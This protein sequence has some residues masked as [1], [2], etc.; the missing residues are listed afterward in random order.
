MMSLDAAMR[1]GV[2]Q[3]VLTEASR[4]GAKFGAQAGLTDTEWLAVLVE[5]V[6]EAARELNETGLAGQPRDLELLRAEVIQV[7]AVALRWLEAVERRRPA[8]VRSRA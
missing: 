4:A 6:G 8:P 1:L 7:A 5:E 3:E 2:V